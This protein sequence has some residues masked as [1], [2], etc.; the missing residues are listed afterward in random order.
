MQMD[1]GADVRGCVRSAEYFKYLDHSPLRHSQFFSFSL[2]G[3][4]ALK[5][6]EIYFC[7]SAC[8]APKMGL[9]DSRI[10]S[11]VLDSVMVSICLDAS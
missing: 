1:L 8:S 11:T 9:V 4:V 2:I 3:L 5:N 6:L 7:I 10:S